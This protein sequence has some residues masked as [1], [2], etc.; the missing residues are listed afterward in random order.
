MALYLLEKDFLRDLDRTSFISEG[1]KERVGLQKYLL[2]RIDII[3]PDLFVIT[4]EFSEWEDSNRRIDILCIDRNANLVV[5]EIKRDSDGGHMEL[6]SVRYAS[7]VSSLK[8]E[9]LV[10]IYKQYLVKNGRVSDAEQSLDSILNFLG[11]DSPQE[12]NFANDTRVI[13]VSEDFSKEI[14]TSVL[15]LNERDIDITCIRISPYK[16]NDMLVLEVQQVIPLPEAQEYQIQIKEKLSEKRQQSKI[17]SLEEQLKSKEGIVRELYDKLKEGIM[18]F[19]KDIKEVLGKGYVDFR[20]NTTFVN[21]GFRK[22]FIKI[23]I[24]MGDEKIDDPKGFCSEIPK[25]FSYGRMTKTFDVKK[26]DDIDYAINLIK[27]AYDINS[28]VQQ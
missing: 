3:S 6:Q 16:F 14:T 18:G 22:N 23:M 28:P 9:T 15:W 20:K 24:K 19:G 21:V 5:I 8:F 25:S 2:N 10:D 17:I 12:D 26:L 27:Q 4:E 13:L 7:M 11:W 1:I